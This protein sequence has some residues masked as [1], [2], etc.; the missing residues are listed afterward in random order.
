M[1]GKAYGLQPATQV[2]AAGRRDEWTQGIVNAPVW[3]AS[4][5]LYDSVADLR[6]AVGDTHHRLFYGRRGTPTQWSLADA[7]T[8]LE[9]GA[10]GTFLYPSGVAAIAAAMLAILSPGDEILITDSAYDPTRSLVKG[11]LA[12]MGIKSRFYDPLIGAGID[13]LVGRTRA[14]S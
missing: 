12:R 6:A 10:E 3:R 11:L 13:A 14:P 9:P 4:T 5:I 2:V 8:T 7:L 1:S